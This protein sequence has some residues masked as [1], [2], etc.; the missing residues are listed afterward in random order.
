MDIEK[1]K[2]KI[3]DNH[4][5]AIKNPDCIHPP[6]RLFVVKDPAYLTYPPPLVVCLHC[7]RIVRD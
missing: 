4:N 3:E 6:N 5:A 1:L 2:K 7:G